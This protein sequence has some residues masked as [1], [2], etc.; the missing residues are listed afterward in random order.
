MG[1]RTGSFCKI[2]SVEP[3]KSTVT[4]ARVSIS[5]KNK[6][7]GQYDQDFSGFISFIGT[8]AASKAAKLKE[9]D[10]I[11]LGDIDVT[12]TYDKEKKIT[13]TNFSVYT[14]E[15]EGAQG[16]QTAPAPEVDDGE[17]EDDERLPF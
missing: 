5:K 14:F 3:V 11:K 7:T 4:R 2:W 9:G 1:F 10:R 15:V 12:N 17:P 8:A 16:S 13:Y 6:Q